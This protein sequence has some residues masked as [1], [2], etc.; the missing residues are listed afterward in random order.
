M[1]FFFFFSSRRRHTIFDCDWSSD[2][3]SSD[4]AG[5]RRL[6]EVLQ[7]LAHGQAVTLDYPV[8]RVVRL[9]PQLGRRAGDERS[10]EAVAGEPVAERVEQAV[11]AS[12]RVLA[13]TV[14]LVGQPLEP[15]GAPVLQ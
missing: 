6:G 10:V 7:E 9:A 2:V 4:L 14:Q 15:V 8:G 11:E 3:C 5:A 1:V 12:L 13:V